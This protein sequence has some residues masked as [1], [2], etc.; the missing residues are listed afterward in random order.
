MHL[1]PGLPADDFVAF[2]NDIKNFFWH[3]DKVP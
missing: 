3:T 2:I 1:A